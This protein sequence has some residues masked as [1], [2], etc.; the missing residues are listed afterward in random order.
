MARGKLSLSILN[1][2]ATVRQTLIFVWS[3]AA[4]AEVKLITSA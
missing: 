1:T 3:A 4:P 2:T